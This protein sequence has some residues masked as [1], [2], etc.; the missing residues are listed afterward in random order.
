MKLA[1]TIEGLP[2][3]R[4]TV[5]IAFNERN[6]RNALSTALTRTA[7]EL[8]AEWTGELFANIDR[9]TAFTLRSPT[10][11]PASADTLRAELFIRDQAARAGDPSPA[12]WLGP[13]ERGGSRLVKKFERAL[14]AQGAMPAGMKVVT[15]K[16]ATLDGYG[17]ISRGQ[18]TQVIAQL[19]RDFSPGYARTISASASRRLA[20]A[21]RHG[22]QY[23]AV[24]Q[25]KG[26]LAPGVYQRSGRALLPVFLYVRSVSYRPRLDLERTGLQAG[27]GILRTQ[28]ARA[29]AEAI[30]R[31]VDRLAAAGRSGGA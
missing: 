7:R 23:V 12:D 27:P 21:Q 2:A 28:I 17:N 25:R 14:M 1:C 24:L 5:E 4:R 18:I 29:L 19:G 20:S 9:P 15:G 30:G 13:Q 11:K 22:R 6:A 26:K 16:Y 31:K 10:V 3:A 8:Q